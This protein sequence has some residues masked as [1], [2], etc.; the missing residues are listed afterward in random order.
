M[1]IGIMLTANEEEIWVA[2]AELFFLDTENKEEDFTRVAELLRQNGWNRDSTEM[3]LVRLI[4]PNA[5][6]NLGFLLWP[7]IGAW[8]GFDARAL[9]EKIHQTRTARN[10]KWASHLFISDWWCR[11]MLRRLGVERLLSRI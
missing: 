2:L 3:V 6:A 11:R 4:A 7:T 1:V 8:S 9:C 10:N 5:G